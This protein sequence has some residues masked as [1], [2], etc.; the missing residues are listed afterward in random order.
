M[1]PQ[2]RVK[3]RFLNLEPLCN[4][5]YKMLLLLQKKESKLTLSQQERLQWL[6]DYESFILEIYEQS[7]TMN[8]LLKI[9][10]NEGLI[11]DTAKRCKLILNKMNCAPYFKEGVIRLV[12]L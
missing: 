12:T 9:L 10:K 5:A 3:G 7:Q 1:P 11:K 2:Q 4:W 6:E 8:Q